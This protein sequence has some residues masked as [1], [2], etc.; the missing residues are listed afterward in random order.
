[1]PKVMQNIVLLMEP[2]DFKSNVSLKAGHMLLNRFCIDEDAA[3]ES[4]GVYYLNEFTHDM[5]LAFHRNSNLEVQDRK[6]RSDR[7]VKGTRK[8]ILTH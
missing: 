8:Y 5:L 3:F 1:M 2:N 6:W 7:K 4:T